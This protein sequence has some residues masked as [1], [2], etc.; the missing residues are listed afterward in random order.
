MMTLWRERALVVSA[1]L[2]A[3]VLRPDAADVAAA[4]ARP[5]ERLRAVGADHVAADLA[6]GALWLICVWLTAA[7]VVVIAGHAPGALG[8]AARRASR[9]V[10]PRL[11]RR[12]IAAAAGASV[13]A[14]P[15]LAVAD[16]QPGSAPTVAWPLSAPVGPSPGWPLTPPAAP[17]PPTP[18]PPRPP[19]TVPPPPR[20][21][22]PG[23][24]PHNDPAAGSTVVVQ[25]GDS[26][27]SIAAARLGPG[28]TDADIA[29]AW[30]AWH[31][32]NADAIGAD[33]DLIQP[34]T[35]LR[36][37]SEGDPT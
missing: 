26:L 30:P 6:G 33:P 17:A 3:V 20:P 35:A 7:S 19:P 15:A 32:A 25:P 10:A 23:P 31:R 34:G 36:A 12:A 16:P 37:P 9:R 24:G 22:P 1:W 4:A 27:W 11:V 5:G 8:A 13:L 29:A 2:G 18:G 21:A 28:A 14:A